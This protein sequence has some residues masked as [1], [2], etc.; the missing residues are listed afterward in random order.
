LR[1][2]RLDINLLFGSN[3]E[4]PF[5]KLQLVESVRLIPY[6]FTPLSLRVLIESWANCESRFLPSSCVPTPKILGI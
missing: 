5:E 6:N 2:S 3:D 4:I 1:K